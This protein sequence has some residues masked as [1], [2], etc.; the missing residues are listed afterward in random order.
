AREGVY[1]LLFEPAAVADGGARLRTLGDPALDRSQLQ[2]ALVAWF[3]RVA[4]T[5]ALLIAV[6]DAQRSDH[7]SAAWLAG[8][9]MRAE[10][11]R[12][13]L[14]LTCDPPSSDGPADAFAVLQLLAER[15]PIAAL[16]RDATQTLLASIFGQV[17]QLALLSERLFAI[18]LGSPRETLALAE[19]LVDSTAIRYVHGQWTLPSDLD[20]GQL[21]E[22]AMQAFAA[23]V[24]A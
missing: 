11:L 8:L 5:H 12:L 4:E 17:P 2:A 9:A 24:R 15:E 10:D 16:D 23:R 14:C 20:S 21:P 1:E 13:L 3:A 6:D 19:Y 22:S 7:P 18:A